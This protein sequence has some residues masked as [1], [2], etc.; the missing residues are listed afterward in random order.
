MAYDDPYF[1]EDD[2]QAALRLARQQL[3]ERKADRPAYEMTENAPQ[4]D[5]TPQGPWGRTF[6][7]VT[8]GR[9]LENDVSNIRSRLPSGEDYGQALLNQRDVTQEFNSLSGQNLREGYANKNI[10]QMA[11]G[12]RQ[13]ALGFVNPAL[14]PI[15]AGFDV[16]TQTAAKFDPRA[17]AEAEVIGLVGTEGSGAVNKGMK[18]AREMAA[19]HPFLASAIPAA[20]GH[21]ALP[22]STEAA[23]PV[24]PSAANWQIEKETGLPQHVYDQGYTI[25]AYHSTVAEKDFAPGSM[26]DEN[27]FGV[28]FGTKEAAN[29]R[30]SGRKEELGIGDDTSRDRILPVAIKLKRPLELEDIGEWNDKREVF[31]A[32][33]DVYP[34][35]SKQFG[36][37]KSKHTLPDGRVDNIAYWN[38][39]PELPEIKKFLQKKG[40][41]GIVY[42]NQFE[43]DGGNSY[44]VFDPKKNVK[45][46]FD[47]PQS[48]EPELSAPVVYDN[49]HANPNSLGLYSRAQRILEEM[50][51]KEGTDLQAIINQMKNKDNSVVKEL[52]DFGITDRKG[53]INPDLIEAYADIPIKG[54]DDLIALLNNVSPEHIKEIVFKKDN[55]KNYPKNL[56]GTMQYLED[57]AADPQKF[58]DFLEMHNVHYDHNNWI[59]SDKHER[60]DFLAHNHFEDAEY[61]VQNTPWVYPRTDESVELFTRDLAAD[62]NEFE[63]FVNDNEMRGVLAENPIRNDELN[64]AMSENGTFE[65]RMR[66]LENYH[67]GDLMDYIAEM[68][69]PPGYP[70]YEPYTMP[71]GTNY[72]ERI[73]YLDP[74]R[75]G[76]LHENTDHSYNLGD[77][78]G[79]INR[80]YQT[81]VK[82]YINNK[83]EKVRFVDES[84]NDQ[85]T[86]AS[87]Q[88]VAEPLSNFKHLTPEKL[89]ETQG[90]RLEERQKDHIKNVASLRE[91]YLKKIE[92]AK[93]KDYQLEAAR[94]E[95]K[96]ESLDENYKDFLSANK[97]KG[98]KVDHYIGNDPSN[99]EWRRLALKRE[100][101]DAVDSGMDKL[102]INN[103][104]NI[105]KRWGKNFKNAYDKT[106]ASD[107]KSILNELDSKLIGNFKQE[108]AGLDFAKK[109]GSQYGHSDR[110]PNGATEH[111]PGY[112]YRL[113][114]DLKMQMARYFDAPGIYKKG[115]S[116]KEERAAMHDW[117][118]S[119]DDTA[120]ENKHAEYL[121][122]ADEMSVINITPELINAIKTKGFKH[123]K[124]GGRV[125][126][127]GGGLSFSNIATQ[128]S[129]GETNPDGTPKTNASSPVVPL[130]ADSNPYTSEGGGGSGGAGGGPGNDSSTGSQAGGGS[131][132]SN[133]ADSTG[134]TGGN[135][136]KRGGRVSKMQESEHNVIKRALTL[137]NHGSP[138]SDAMRIARQ[139]RGRP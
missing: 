117:W 114:N 40:H 115:I 56:E 137:S 129:E 112:V 74:K 113:G 134:T 128:G 20:L 88:G 15:N 23:K 139:H 48:K 60:Y 116:G 85:A 8:G 29:D 13:G 86:A 51:I 126:K 138:L 84:Q 69:T 71:G 64:H 65:D 122:K 68:I 1:P 77:G 49:P 133:N 50:N 3:A 135:A 39:I 42:E 66:Y 136:E 33:Q 52:A 27:G 32:V 118:N 87:K 36:V 81:R 47:L 9:N 100:L 102:V 35:I 93:A 95:V 70:Q 12:A 92:E 53:T 62:R 109:G 44:I 31:A 80:L 119:M 96:L 63:N 14:A 24:T 98:V 83:G 19:E 54:K 104:L 16:L 7:A 59:D 4:T 57:V 120:K 97:T 121:K 25:P 72:Q 108:D 110:H 125:G 58:K 94:M 82:D 6:A 38:S 30:L 78:E 89:L 106:M 41:D 123:R 22:E 18:I 5:A 103:G 131:R 132:D 105:S 46:Q 61:A 26:K 75:Y 2:Q 43:G 76:I 10:P 90:G 17:K 111:E 37:D 21:N 55:T 79:N 107:V 67:G 130:V 99:T 45:S 127:A 101:I 11:L 73:G 91:N 124:S 34:E 28:H